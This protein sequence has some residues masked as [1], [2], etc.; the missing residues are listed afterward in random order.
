MANFRNNL[1]DIGVEPTPFGTHSFR[2][3]GVQYLSTEKRWNIRKLCD[4]GGWSMDFESLTIV[5]YLISWNDDPVKKREDFMN[6]EMQ[7]G[8][9]CPRCNRTCD[10]A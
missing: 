10:C 1:A 4:W 8:V 5:R 2:R 6:S 3:G 9:F 7:M